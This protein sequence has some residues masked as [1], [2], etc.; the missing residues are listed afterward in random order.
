M[1]CSDPSRRPAPF[2]CGRGRPP[3]TAA[4]LVRRRG[5]GHPTRLVIINPD[6]W[7]PHPRNTCPCLPPT[8]PST[9]GLGLRKGDSEAP[10][11]NK[12]SSRMSPSLPPPPNP[13]EVSPP[14]PA[15]RLEWGGRPPPPALALSL[16]LP[17]L[18]TLRFPPTRSRGGKCV[19]TRAS[20]V[21]LF[22]VQSW[23]LAKCSP[24]VGL[25]QGFPRAGAQ[26]LLFIQVKATGG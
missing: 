8:S 15:A 22:S 1:L 11:E 16:N 10:S 9:S 24:V 26:D 25:L 4:A 14:Q 6:T 18:A 20:R 7:R 19:Q 21:R 23:A 2:R 3:W 17:A 12:R 5:Q 13:R